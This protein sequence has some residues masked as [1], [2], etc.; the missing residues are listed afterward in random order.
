MGME[1]ESPAVP[2]AVFW[3]RLKIAGAGSDRQGKFER[4]EA[5][6]SQRT[7]SRTF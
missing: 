2:I 1:E 5:L 4:L 7:G 6:D 3:E